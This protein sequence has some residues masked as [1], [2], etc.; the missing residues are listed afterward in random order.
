MRHVRRTDAVLLGIQQLGV[1]GLVLPVCHRVL[2]PRLVR[3]RE[4]QCML[5]LL[6]QHSLRI[7]VSVVLARSIE[8]G[9]CQM[10]NDVVESWW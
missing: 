6:P 1:Q 8:K 4:A 10:G 7:V 9:M 3:A 2:T 5:N